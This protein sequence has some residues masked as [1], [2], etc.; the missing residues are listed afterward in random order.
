VVEN[1]G[2][3]FAK[4]EKTK[5]SLK[6]IQRFLPEPKYHNKILADVKSPG[7]EAAKWEQVALAKK[8]PF[9]RQVT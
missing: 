7:P 8:Y 1:G 9:Q 4:R 6:S 5:K 2:D 3:A